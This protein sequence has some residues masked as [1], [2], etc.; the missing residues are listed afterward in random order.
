MEVYVYWTLGAILLYGIIARSIYDHTNMR[1]VEAWL[2]PVW[3]G[4]W[5]VLYTALALYAI[6]CG[7]AIVYHR[8]RGW[9]YTI[10]LRISLWRQK[11]AYLK[12]SH[13]VEV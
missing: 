1:E 8:V 5:A 6:C 13:K 4:A 3:V 7:V 11:R 12:R 2:W 10:T 9:Y